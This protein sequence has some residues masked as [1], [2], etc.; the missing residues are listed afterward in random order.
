MTI[1]FEPG[2][3]AAIYSRSC[4]L[5]GSDRSLTN[6]LE[7]MTLE[8]RGNDF[9]K[10]SSKRRRRLPFFRGLIVDDG[11]DDVAD[12]EEVIFCFL[13]DGGF[14]IVSPSWPWQVQAVREVSWWQVQALS[15]LR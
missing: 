7:S 8:V 4:C 12:S 5:V 9:S 10:R 1:S 2:H 6:E 15:K 3:R 13:D 14:D 11:E